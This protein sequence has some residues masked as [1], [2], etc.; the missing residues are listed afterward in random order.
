M[1][2]SHWRASRLMQWSASYTYAAAKFL[3]GTYAGHWIPAVPQH[4]VDVGWRADWTERL[5]SSLNLRYIGRSYLISDQANAH[6]KL[7][8]YAIADAVVN[9]R[10]QHVRMFARVDNLTN[11]KYSTY[12]V[13]SSSGTDSYYPAAG[14]AVSAGA[15]YRF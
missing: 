5:A 14:I 15:D 1:V 7:P 12:G 10:W 9:Y 6:A 2:S 3:N 11:R 4:R 8:G 13:V